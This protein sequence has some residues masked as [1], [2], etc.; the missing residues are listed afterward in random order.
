MDVAGNA[1]SATNDPAV[2]VDLT[3]PTIMGS[4]DIAPALSGWYNLGTGAPTYS[5][6]ATDDGSGLADP[7]GDAYTFGEGADQTHT[8]T[9]SD[10][11]GNAT[12]VTND[13]AVSVDLTPPTIMGNLDIGPAASGWYNL[14]TGSPTYSYTATD[15]GSGLADPAGDAYTFGEGA[16]QTHT[17]T[18]MDVAGNATSVTNDPAVSVDL[19]PPT[20]LGNLDIAPA[21]S[22]W[23]N[24]GTGAPTYSYTA[25]DDGSGLADPAGDAYTFG[26]G[27]DQTHTFTVSDV[28][29]N[30]TSVT[31]DPAV[32]VDLTPPTILGNLDIGPA[33]SGWYNL[34]TG[35]PTYSYTA[36]D[37]GS[38]LADPAGDS[39][40]FGEGADQTHTFTVMDVA[41]NA[42]SATNDPAVSVD[43][44]PPTITGSLDIAPALSGWYN[45]GTGAP[46]YSYTATDD[47]SGLVDPAGDAYTFGEG[48]DQTHT[49][50][51]SDVAGNATSVTNDPAVS[52]DLTPP[53]ILGN[54]DIGPAASGWYN[55]GTG[56]PTYSYTAT[57]DGSGLADPA[58]DAYTFGEGADQTHTFTVMDVAGNATSVTNDPAVS[59]DLT[60]PTILGN[61]D[62]APAAERLVQPREPAHRHT[63][64]RRRT[65]DRAWRTRPATPTRLARGRIKRTLS[66]SP[67]WRG[68]P[69][70]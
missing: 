57:D 21:A 16:D 59:V 14:G 20:I 8:F 66:R 50:T 55:L 70:A 56:A 34:G 64:T 25:T 29:G 45:L 24:L 61:L 35:A 17:F 7:A 3:P 51:V 62:I 46:T 11:A 6:T 48:A 12:S 41:G 28:A 5:Y 52:V 9:V 40:T 26:E 23:Y 30:A 60:P 43:L 65:T 63:A 15:D 44:T 1:A 69:R 18:V 49:F 38:G 68:M 13:P 47:G 27:A 37:D 67:T 58:G 2:S 10:V 33:A 19:T 36:T 22:G 54:L 31:N 32:S 42:A 39:Y 53:T 4:L